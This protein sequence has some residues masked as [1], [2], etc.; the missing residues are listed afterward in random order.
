MSYTILLGAF[1]KLENSTAQPS[2]ALW[3][4][5][6]ITL[7]HGCNYSNPVVTISASFAVIKP[8]NYAKLFDRYYFVTDIQV[9]REN[10]CTLYLKIDVLA[11]Y[12]TTIGA[13]TLYVLR[14]ASQADGNISDSF[15]ATKANSTKYRDLQPYIPVGGHET[16]VPGDYS[17]GIVLLNIA[18]TSDAGA[19]TLWELTTADFAELVAAIYRDID[20]YSL[21]DVIAKVVQAFGG[22]PQSLINS[23]MW[24][25]FPF[26]VDSVKAVKIG[27][28]KAKKEDPDNPGSYINITGGLV[29]DPLIYLPDVTFTLQKH[30]LAATRGAYLNLAPY[31]QYTLGLPG[32]GVINLDNSKLQ[33]ETTITVE[34]CMDAYTG[35][36]FVK[37]KADA[38]GQMLAYMNGQIGI[39]I[40]L[41]GSNNANSLI[42][43][44]LSTITSAIAAGLMTGPM[45]PAAVAGAYASGINLAVDTVAGTPTSSSMG[46]GFAGITEERIWLDTLCVDITD[47]DNTEHGRP[48]C[49][50]KQINTL[51]GYTVVADG[52]VK[53]PGPLPEQQEVKRFL[54]T[55]F[56]YE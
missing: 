19:S 25:P 1:S 39:P 34:R 3:P 17:S 6:D 44:G 2:T 12:K 11:T 49:K 18:G 45:A 8:Y 38:S 52:N 14:S 40:Q 48:L 56:Y 55:G 7:K 54:E 16:S 10:L 37:V 47:A 28:W 46:A 20:G 31:T 41:R 22:N 43:G 27:S 50:R 42:G 33:G 15:Y 30:P 32:V 13:Y 26:D 9:E 35:Q 53:I 4:S 24:F 23:A 36:L 51:S 21:G 29:V 5:Y